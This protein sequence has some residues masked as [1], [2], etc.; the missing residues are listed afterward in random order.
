MSYESFVQKVN[1]I[2]R[3][4]GGKYVPIFINDADR[5]NFICH[6][7]DDSNTRIIGSSTSIKVCVRWGNNADSRANYSHQ[8]IVTI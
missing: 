6:L 7:N 3:R 4:S 5:G 2:I 8:S 1:A